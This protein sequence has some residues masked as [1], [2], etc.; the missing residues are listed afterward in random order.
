M[1]DLSK[2]H[3][4]Y[5]ELP[6]ETAVF[7]K[8]VWR[9]NDPLFVNEVVQEAIN[10]DVAL[11]SFRESGDDF[12]VVN[13][14]KL[15][16]Y[17]IETLITLSRPIK[18]EQEFPVNIRIATSDDAQSCANIAAVCFRDDRYHMDQNIDDEI[19]NEIK[20]KWV[21]NSVSGRADTVF[22]CELNGKTV[23]FNACMYRDDIAI[24][25]LI[26]VLPDY[27]GQG[28]G[29]QLI[30]AMDS[31]YSKSTTAIQLGTQLTN[32]ASQNFYKNLGFKELS[33]QSTW[34]WWNKSTS[35]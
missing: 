3:Q 24:I 23:G 27:Q 22:I 8:P 29:N 12:D 33:R 28:I 15:G 16:F 6:F 7:S 19:A 13:F 1:L 9:L 4:A 31:H 18:P 2:F 17:Q 14:K 35:N 25:D 32:I 30:Q 34:H 10:N 11:I 21:F 5:S 26:G 20:S